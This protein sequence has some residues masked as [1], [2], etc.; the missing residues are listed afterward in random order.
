MTNWKTTLFGAGAIILGLLGPVLNH[1]IPVVGLDWVTV[2][3][4]LASLAAGGGLLAAKDSSTHS[5]DAQVAKATVAE[6]IKETP[7]P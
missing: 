5:T 1:Y 7:K 6:A 2:C 4:A 3:S